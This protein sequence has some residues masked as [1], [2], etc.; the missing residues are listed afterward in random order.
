M[1][2][3]RSLLTDQRVEGVEF[4]GVVSNQLAN[5]WL[6]S[7][8][9]VV[10]TTLTEID[11]TIVIGDLVEVHGATNHAGGVDARRLSLVKNHDKDDDMEVSPP[12][13]P[14]LAPSGDSGLQDTPEESSV[15][16]ELTGEG[17]HESSDGDGQLPEKTDE[18][19]SSGDLN[20][21]DR[22]ESGG[23]RAG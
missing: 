10:V 16:P 2:E 4:T 23:E 8:I 14:T 7:G 9:H 18:N 1:D 5:E 21:S 11:G 17:G 19:H 22:S 12:P 13:A 6:V 20:H 15:T 3:T